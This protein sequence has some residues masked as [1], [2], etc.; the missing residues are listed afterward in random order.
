MARGRFGMLCVVIVKTSLGVLSR[1][2]MTVFGIMSVVRGEKVVTTNRFAIVIV[3]VAPQWLTIAS[4]P[5]RQGK[6]SLL[7]ELS[8]PAMGVRLC[9]Y[10]H[11]A[12][13]CMRGFCH[14]RLC[15]VDC[16]LACTDFNEDPV[17]SRRI[18]ASDLART[19]TSSQKLGFP[20]GP[21]LAI[22]V[23]QGYGV[24]GGCRH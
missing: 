12:R 18:R 4:V 14:R 19:N 5:G 20:S 10:A 3:A 11:L 2:W 22:S 21:R 6:Q 17:R 15:A 1:G 9:L 7:L 8:E 13:H 24:I 16:R 23:H